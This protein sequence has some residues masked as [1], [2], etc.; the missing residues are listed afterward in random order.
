MTFQTIKLSL[1]LY[2]LSVMLR[3]QRWRHEQ[4]LRMTHQ[5]IREEM[6]NL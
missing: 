6:K 4:D 2:G 3:F 1:I 5:E